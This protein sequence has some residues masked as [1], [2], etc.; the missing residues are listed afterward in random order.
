MNLP[1]DWK[2]E[3]LGNI[4]TD[5]QLEMIKL[6]A[7]T[8]DDQT[9][10]IRKLKSY[11]NTPRLSQHLAKKNHDPTFMAYAVGYALTKER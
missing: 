1:K 6:I 5:R 3:P 7:G 9:E 11:F 8:T 2:S 10:A 4:F